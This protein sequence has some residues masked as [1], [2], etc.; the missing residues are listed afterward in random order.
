MSTIVFGDRGSS[1]LV[2][3]RS[4]TLARAALAALAAPSILNTQPWRWRIDGDLLHLRADRN[5]QATTLD[6]DGRLL[7]LSCG[8]ALHHATVALAADGIATETTTLPN[9]DDPDLLATIRHLGTTPITPNHTRMRRAMANR[10][11][12]RRPFADTPIRPNTLDNLRTAAETHGVHLHYPPTQ[13]LTTLTVAAGRAATAELADPAYRAEL[14]DWVAR[15]SAGQEG[16]PEA[17]IVPAAARPVP[18]RQFT[19]TKPDQTTIHDQLPVA[20]RYARYAVL[21]TNGDT[22]TDWLTAGQALSAVLLT[23][24]ADGL[25]TSPMSDLVEVPAARTLL[26][27]LLAGIGHPAI[28]IR[29]GVPAPGEPATSPH[30]PSVWSTNN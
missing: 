11:T 14:A 3:E 26:R 16:V 9:P 12:D 18:V 4:R 29:I 2:S 10:H 23:A 20:D 27:D 17:T 19:A 25:A 28:V 24:T 21:F 30:R 15:A 1:P 8:A 5:R 7:T 6:P 22:P 13:D